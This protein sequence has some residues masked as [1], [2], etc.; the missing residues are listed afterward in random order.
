MCYCTIQMGHPSSGQ[1]F[2]AIP[3]VQDRNGSTQFDLMLIL[4]E[5]TSVTGSLFYSSDI[6]SE[7]TAA[8]MAGHF[9]VGS[10]PKF[11]INVAM[12]HNFAVNDICG[13]DV[14]MQCS[15]QYSA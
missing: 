8:R 3:C 11:T 15:Q 1:I 9:K 6:F 13:T 5:G 14:G 7:E 2:K 4:E 12:L 10:D